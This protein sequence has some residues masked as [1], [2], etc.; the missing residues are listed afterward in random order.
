M[1][2]WC[3]VLVCHLGCKAQLLETSLFCESTSCTAVG[4]VHD[5]PAD[6][7]DYLVGYKSTSQAAILAWTGA[8]TPFSA[9]L[10]T[11]HTDR[12]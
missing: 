4:Q 8:R 7:H 6:A 1:L 9:A 2:S 10:G 12:R 11:T 3:M 5:R